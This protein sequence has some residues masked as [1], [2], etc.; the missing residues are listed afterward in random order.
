MRKDFIAITDFTAEEITDVLEM[1]Q[2]L[3]SE[4]GSDYQP[5]KGK[6]LAMIFAKPSARTRVSFETGMYQLGGHAIYL[7]PSDIQMGERE[8]VKDVAQVL[9][10]YNDG[11]MARLFD[12]SQM[13][14]LARYASVPVINGL[15]DYNH[16]CQV[17]SD[18]FTV[19]EKRGS[20]D[21]LTVAFVGD[22]NNVANSWINLASRLPF[23]L[24]IATPEG[25]EPDAATVARAKEAAAGEVELVREPKE[26]VK[27]ADVIY[28]DAWASMGRESEAEERRRVFEGYRVDDELVSLAKKEC[29]VMHC[30]PAHRGEEITDSVMDGPHSVIFE[31]AENRLH[32]QKAI[33]VRLMG[34]GR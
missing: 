8:A 9:S 18:I 7:A 2:W 34:G 10:R 28:T 14:E 32:V 33:L 6:T 19:R 15:T 24:V 26:A 11:I 4:A 1:A 31:Q 17:L 5:L 29:I 27:E 25:Y 20:L 21:D 13:E 3:K 30:L 23:R 16:P 22:G 12:H